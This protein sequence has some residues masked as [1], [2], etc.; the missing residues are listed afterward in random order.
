MVRRIRMLMPTIRQMENNA[1][2]VIEQSPKKKGRH[3]AR[4]NQ[5]IIWVN[6]PVALLS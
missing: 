5:E 1:M 2:S 4:Y 6:S 3:G